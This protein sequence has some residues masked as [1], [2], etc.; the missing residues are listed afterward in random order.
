MEY[1][2]LGFNHY[3]VRCLA[4]GTELQSSVDV[5]LQCG[6]C[7]H[8]SMVYKKLM[9]QFGTDKVIIKNYVGKEEGEGEGGRGEERERERERE[10]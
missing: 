10:R 3:K 6:Q 5:F 4:G 1:I 2:E 9:S 8:I 7:H